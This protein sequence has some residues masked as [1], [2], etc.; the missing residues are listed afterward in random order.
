MCPNQLD[1][2]KVITGACHVIFYDHENISLRKKVETTFNG[3]YGMTVYQFLILWN[4]IHD[5]FNID[6]YFSITH[7]L[8]TLYFLKQYQSRNVMTVLFR[9]SKNT[10]SKWIWYTLDLISNLNL[11]SNIICFHIL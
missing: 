7:L 2:E 4:L 11:V 8:W 3:M 1:D 5:Q 10:L 9:T 6:T